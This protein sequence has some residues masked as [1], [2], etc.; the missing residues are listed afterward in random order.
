MALLL[1]GGLTAAWRYTYEP[2]VS[3]LMLS[4]PWNTF[5][6]LIA[7]AALGAVAERKQLRTHP[8]LGVDRKGVLLIDDREIPV[9]VDNVSTGGCCIRPE[10]A[11]DG[12]EWR[13]NETRGRLRIE[14][15][16]ESGA[17]QTVPIVFKHVAPRNGK[18]LYGFA[19]DGLEPKTISRSPTLCSATVEQWRAS[20]PAGAHTRPFLPA[21]SNLRAGIDWAAAGR[22]VAGRTRDPRSSGRVGSQNPGGFDAMAAPP[23][24]A[25]TR[26]ERG[27]RSA[28]AALSRSA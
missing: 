4:Q 19:F 11:I 24:G 2:G 9:I 15:L 25:R 6:M 23:R 8:R 28:P 14:A 27:A 20:S 7:G 10:T 1:A 3:N 16:G 17:D 21:L 12:P 5:N 26:A 13:K 22:R 18:R